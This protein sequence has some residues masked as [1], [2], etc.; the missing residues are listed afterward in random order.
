MKHQLSP[1]EAALGKLLAL[2]RPQLAL[3]YNIADRLCVLNG[4]SVEFI[5]VEG[6]TVARKWQRCV[7]LFQHRL[8][9]YD[10][11]DGLVAAARMVVEAPFTVPR[12]AAKGTQNDAPPP[13][14][15]ESLGAQLIEKQVH[16]GIVGWV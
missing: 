5:D 9:G 10:A 12:T 8:E 15:T 11:V 2:Q 7:L 16:G 13:P 3:W 4:Y 6:V 14:G 1:D